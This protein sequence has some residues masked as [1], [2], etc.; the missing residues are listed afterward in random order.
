MSAEAIRL[1]RLLTELLP[2]PEAMGLLALMLLHESRRAARTSPDGELIL[3][4]AQDRSLWD[5]GQIAEGQALVER[6]I[7]SRRFGPYTLQAAIAAVHAEA[8]DAAETDWRQIVGLYD[9]LMRADGSP[10]IELNRAVAVAMCDGPFAGLAL[11]DA[12]LARG[13]LVDYHLTHSARADLCRRLGRSREA[14]ESYQRALTL[15]RQEPERR[16]LERR[17]GKLP[18]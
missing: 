11:I 10:V 12:I 8:R 16:F 4:D 17:L 15:T 18:D 9:V 6:A 1:G 2:E 13:D 3:L 7:S 5:R 14:R